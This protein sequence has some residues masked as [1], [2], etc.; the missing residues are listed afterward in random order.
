MNRETADFFRQISGDERSVRRALEGAELDAAQLQVIRG[1]SGGVGGDP[2]MSVRPE[3]RRFHRFDRG[4]GEEGNR[5]FARRQTE[6]LEEPIGGRAGFFGRFAVNPDVSH[7]EPE[8]KLDGAFRVR[9]NSGPIAR[10]DRRA[11]RDETTAD[12]QDRAAA[13][14]SVDFGPVDCAGRNE[15]SG[16][17]RFGQRFDRGQTARDRRRE[18]VE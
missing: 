7:F 11:R 9:G 12:R 13:G 14:V 2:D 8:K 18:E 17:E 15:T 16:R 1:S 3:T 4:A 10:G 5:R 6:R